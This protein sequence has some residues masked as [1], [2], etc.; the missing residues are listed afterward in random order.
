MASG[1]SSAN[2]KT[3]VTSLVHSSIFSG[4]S[5]LPES[6]RSI[7]PLA[8]TEK[9]AH[10]IKTNRRERISQTRLNFLSKSSAGS[11]STGRQAS[12]ESRSPSVSSTTGMANLMSPGADQ[13]RTVGLQTRDSSTSLPGGEPQ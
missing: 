3:S 11:V 7:E 12:V 1:N 6:E 13:H 4:L 2:R 5:I 9:E 10:P 8:A